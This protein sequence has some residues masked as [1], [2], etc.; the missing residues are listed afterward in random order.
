MASELTCVRRTALQLEFACLGVFSFL[1]VWIQNP[2]Q[3]ATSIDSLI[4]NRKKLN[5][6]S[7][8]SFTLKPITFAI[9]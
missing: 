9:R 7:E 1:K 6:A 8:N 2:L 4:I 5:S 3:I